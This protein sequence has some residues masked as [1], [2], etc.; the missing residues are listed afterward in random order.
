[1]RSL[2]CWL[3]VHEGI[4]LK[5]KHGL[6]IIVVKLYDCDSEMIIELHL[7]QALMQQNNALA[8]GF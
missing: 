6:F 1:M 7:C 8:N 2:L 5:E 4:T 3:E